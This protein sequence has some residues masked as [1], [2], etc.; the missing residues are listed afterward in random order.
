MLSGEEESGRGSLI[1]HQ[2]C[3]CYQLPP[4]SVNSEGIDV[5]GHFSFERI[6]SNDDQRSSIGGSEG[7]TSFG[8]CPAR[9]AS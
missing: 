4:E 2:M 9:R 7:T 8:Q 5:F 6:P 3:V 1:D